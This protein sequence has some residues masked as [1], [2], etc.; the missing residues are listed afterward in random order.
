MNTKPPSFFSLL[1]LDDKLKPESE[2]Q[3]EGKK[4]TAGN[5]EK[6]YKQYE[7]FIVANKPLKAL[8]Q[9][10]LPLYN[11]RWAERNGSAENCNRRIFPVALISACIF[12]AELFFSVIIC[13]IKREHIPLM[14]NNI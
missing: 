2:Q 9:H 10:N 4:H 14:E 11:R 12:D 3:D 6:K 8:E 7:A 5:K 13:V 1:V